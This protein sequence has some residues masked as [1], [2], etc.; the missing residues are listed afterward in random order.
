MRNGT[1]TTLQLPESYLDAIDELVD[2]K[3]IMSRSEFMRTSIYNELKLWFG[4][5]KKDE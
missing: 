3:W 4:A 5:L 1:R 2:R